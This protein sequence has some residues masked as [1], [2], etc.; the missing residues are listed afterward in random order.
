[1]AKKYEL[2]AA[3][4]ARII[5]NVGAKRVS[6]DGVETLREIMEDFGTEIARAAY[7]IAK[8]SGRKTV[9][10]KDIKLALK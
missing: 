7:E 2:P 4:I 8:H 6:A 3:P 9:M 5:K 1:M 10:G